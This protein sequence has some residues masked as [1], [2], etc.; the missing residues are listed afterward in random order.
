MN[1]PSQEKP[2][3]K[4]FLQN[5]FTKFSKDIEAKVTEKKKKKRKIKFNINAQEFKPAPKPQMSLPP[6]SPLHPP[7]RR[8][9]PIDINTK[10]SSIFHKKIVTLTTPPAEAGY[11]WTSTKQCSWS[12]YDMDV[13]FMIDIKKEQ[14]QYIPPINPYPPPFFNPR[15]MPMDQYGVYQEVYNFNPY[16]PYTTYVPPFGI[17]Q[18]MMPPNG[19]RNEDS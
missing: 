14:V 12:E 16:P 15:V 9:A 13:P 19:K 11:D 17:Y 2:Q 10:V 1:I 18:N 6:V 7:E 8:P 4:K 5:E 3:D